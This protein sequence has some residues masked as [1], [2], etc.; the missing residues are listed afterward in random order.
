MVRRFVF[1]FLG[2]IGLIIPATFGLAL[3]AAPAQPKP[4]SSSVMMPGCEHNLAAANISLSTT[5]ARF[6]SL[7]AA[8]GP[9]TCS[10]TRLYFLEIVKT[11]A[12]TAVCRRGPERDR[13]LGRLDADV[14]HVNEVIASR[15]NFG[16]GS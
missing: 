11:R 15:C 5:Q 7:G 8:P 12:V 16:Q 13:E 1:A 10:A 6:K 3:L 14:E 2:F 4:I 9:A